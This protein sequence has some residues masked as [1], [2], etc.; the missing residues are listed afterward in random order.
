MG[1]EH[2]EEERKGGKKNDLA[3]LTYLRSTKTSAKTS[4][5]D[6]GWEKC[7]EVTF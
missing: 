4:I 3:I 1:V 7:G 5:G 2:R 6:E